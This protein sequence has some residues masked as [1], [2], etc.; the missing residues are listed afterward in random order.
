MIVR[1]QL[2]KAFLE[3]R[4]VTSVDIHEI[5]M[6]PGQQSRRHQHPCAVV[7]YVVEGIAVYQVEGQDEQI[8]AAGSAFYE[9]ADTTI[10]KFGNASD[11]APMTFVAFYLLD[12]EQELILMME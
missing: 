11:V 1:K 6:D 9:Q 5:R 8:L 3:N 12:G 10:A 7:G 2:L 4:T